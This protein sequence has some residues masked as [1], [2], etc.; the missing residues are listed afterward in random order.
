MQQWTKA[1][2]A[3]SVVWHNPMNMVHEALE[4][5]FKSL[6]TSPPFSFP[7]LYLSFPSEWFKDVYPLD[8]VLLRG[9]YCTL[10]SFR[11]T[12]INIP[13][14]PR[15]TLIPLQIVIATKKSVFGPSTQINVR[16]NDSGWC[17]SLSYHESWI[18]DPEYQLVLLLEGYQRSLFFSLHEWGPCLFSILQQ[19]LQYLR[20]AKWAYCFWY[21]AKISLPY[22]HSFL[23]FSQ[24]YSICILKYTKQ[25]S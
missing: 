4:N 18:I 12:Y 7:P 10:G 23:D 2:M 24:L 15:S 1:Q 13:M 16:Q 22:L 8:A 5:K 14:R 19:W 3:H 9:K 20:E 17:K 21:T 6:H 25:L 11:V